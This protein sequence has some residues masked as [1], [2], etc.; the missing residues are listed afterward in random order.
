[1]A[2][3]EFVDKDGEEG[4]ALRGVHDDGGRRRNISYDAV[5]EVDRKLRGGAQFASG[6][7][8]AQQSRSGRCRRQRGKRRSQCVG[9]HR[10][11]RPMVVMSMVRSSI[12]DEASMAKADLAQAGLAVRRAGGQDAAGG[13]TA[14]VPGSA[15]CA[16]RARDLPARSGS[17]AGPVGA[18]RDGVGARGTSSPSPKHLAALA[19]VLR[20]SVDD[21]IR[22]RPDGKPIWPACVT[23]PVSPAPR[24]PARSAS[25][26]RRGARSSRVTAACL[27][28]WCP[29]SPRSS[30][31]RSR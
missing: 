3:V 6:H 9:A 21:L 14:S 29:G 8:S 2:A 18:G 15:A 16:L 5:F 26:D 28:A 24:S 31:G 17:L 4:A 11:R 20:V 19:E 10:S 1:M 22:I 7:A 27:N 13:T 12:A 23:A 30:T 25:T